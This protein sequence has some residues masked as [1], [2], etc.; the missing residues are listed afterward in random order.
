MAF[1]IINF[2]LFAMVFPKITISSS[3]TLQSSPC[4]PKKKKKET[5]IGRLKPKSSRRTGSF[6][7]FEKPAKKSARCLSSFHEQ[8]RALCALKD[9]KEHGERSRLEIWKIDAAPVRSVRLYAFSRAFTSLSVDFP[10]EFS[11]RTRG[12]RKREKE[13]E[14]EG[15]RERQRETEKEWGEDRQKESSR[16]AL[17]R[18]FNANASCRKDLLAAYFPDRVRTFSIS[19]ERFFVPLPF[20]RR[21]WPTRKK[22]AREILVKPCAAVY[23]PLT[24]SGK[25]ITIRACCV[26]V[27]KRS[28]IGSSGTRTG[29]KHGR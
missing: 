2:L 5:K 7:R 26:S 6:G 22:R 1:Y 9:L 15:E 20:P 18:R 16:A 11:V 29:R 13:E 4:P 28:I 14:K 24:G 3:L 10:R 19:V 8:P 25:R 21:K 23:L 17:V 27:R 12:R